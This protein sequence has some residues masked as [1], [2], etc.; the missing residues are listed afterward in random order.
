MAI[1]R[2]QALVSVSAAAALSALPLQAEPQAVH[3]TTDVSKNEG[4]AADPV[5]LTDFEL[6]AKNKMARMGWE[7]MSAG[8][9][10]ELTLRWNIESYQRIRLKPRVLV[11]GNF[12]SLTGVCN[13]LR[14]D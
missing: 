4:S 12:Q 1:T 7:Y 11:D 14:R 13:R 5:C 2:R 9:A 6:L 8:A 3:P 10:D